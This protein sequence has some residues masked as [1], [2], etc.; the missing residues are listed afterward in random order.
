MSDDSE[1]GVEAMST[2]E[3]LAAAGQS[4]QYIRGMTS[5]DVIR[6]IKARC[7]DPWVVECV[8]K[9]GQDCLKPLG[10]YNLIGP[11]DETPWPALVVEVTRT[12]WIPAQAHRVGYV[13]IYADEHNYVQCIST[14][15]VQQAQFAGPLPICEPRKT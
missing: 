8:R 7:E 14:D 4:L 6:D 2:D 5:L 3:L 10:Q 11:D 13:V 12:P 1:P 15:A 9:L